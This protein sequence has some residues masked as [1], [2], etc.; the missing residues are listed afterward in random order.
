MLV[1]LNLKPDAKQLRQFG[2]IALGAFAVIGAVV[3]WRGGLFGLSF[4]EATQPV[5]Y[6]LWGLGIISALFSLLWPLAN[7]PLFVALI[8]VTFPIGVVVSHVV[9]ALLFFG[10]LTPVALLF[11]LIGR[12]PLEREF[13]RERESYWT[14]LPEAPE[15]INTKDYFR[16]F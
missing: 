8:V 1:Q 12:D 6:G 14:D 11:R 9:L 7:R 2:F 16:Q 3:L 10:I 15:V 4:G 13:D 5:A